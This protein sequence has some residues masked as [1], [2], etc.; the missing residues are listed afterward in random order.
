MNFVETDWSFSE[1][2]PS[3]DSSSSLIQSNSGQYL[4]ADANE[5]LFLPYVGNGYIGI[6]LISKQGL[7]GSFQKSL[8]LQLNYNPLIQIYSETLKK[9]EITGIDFLSGTTY[10]IQCYQDVSFFYICRHQI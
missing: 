8:S 1:K 10:R 9:K 3:E 4:F 5:K 6:S 2:K 7:F